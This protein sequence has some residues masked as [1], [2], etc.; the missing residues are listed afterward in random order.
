MAYLLS[1]RL[2]VLRDFVL[3]ANLCAVKISVV[4]PVFNVEK[5]I[6]RCA[7]SLFEQT[8]DSIEYIF[9]DDCS[10]DGSLGVLMRTLEQ[11][12]DRR[13]NVK[14]ISH[15]RNLGQS[16]A[17]NAGLSASSGEYVAFCDSD[18]WADK[19]MYETMYNIAA[20]SDADVV[21]CD[22]YRDYGNRTEYCNTVEPLADKIEFLG[23]YMSRWTPVWNILAKRSLYINNSLFFPKDITYREDFCL[24]VPLFYYAQKIEKIALP[25]YHYNKTNSGSLL[26]VKN[27]RIES[28]ALYC[29]MEVIDFLKAKGIYNNYDKEMSWGV[30]RD[31]QDMIL[32]SSRH[33][34]FMAIYPESH[35]YIR[36]CPFLNFKMKLM[37]WLVVNHVGFIVSGI[38]VLRAALKR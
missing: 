14:V 18:D 32:D 33:D 3:V 12:P 30:L 37:M 6:E 9:V 8:L 13:N 19:Y 36:S 7:R 4:I 31:K 2:D 22:F 23:Q 27:A 28:D 38:N 1:I 34:E 17:R 11:Y 21:Y 35:R 25:L 16:A 20:Q 26:S 10:S 15:E 29:D 5:H 24:T